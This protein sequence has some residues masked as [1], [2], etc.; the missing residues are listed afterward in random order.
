MNETIKHQLNHR[1]IRFFKDQAVDPQELDLI[2]QV[3]QRTATSNGLQLSSMIRITDPAQKAK[4]AEI[5]QQ[6]YVARAPELVIFL[7]DLYRAKRILQEKGY[8]EENYRSMDQ[9][10]KGVADAYLAA[11]NLTTVVESLGLGA[12]FLGSVLNDSQALVD[13]LE[14]PELTFPL[15]GVAF[16]YPDDQ[17]EL[18][19]RMDLDLRLS[20]NTY[21]VEDDYLDLLADYDQEMTHYYDTRKKNQRSDTYTDQ[22]YRQIETVKPKRA[23]LLQVAE[24]QGF[25][26]KNQ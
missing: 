2:F 21:Q 4:L 12:V 11:Q 9:F 26:L 25:I 22:L 23:N 18:K 8:Q 24:D 13:L 10:F 3:T 5:C 6:D 14:L 15:V 16:G 20:E 1:S 17:P 19:P 7:V